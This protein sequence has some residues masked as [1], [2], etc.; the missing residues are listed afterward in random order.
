VELVSF[1]E[2]KSE[3]KDADQ[4]RQKGNEQ[5]STRLPRLQAASPMAASATR[6]NTKLFTAIHL[7]SGQAFT[8]RKNN[9]QP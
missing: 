6:N 1:D 8:Q 4:N 3:K 5:P 7:E 9:I 2:A